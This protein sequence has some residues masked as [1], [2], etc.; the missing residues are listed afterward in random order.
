MLFWCICF[1][2]VREGEVAKRS[3]GYHYVPSCFGGSVFSNFKLSVWRNRLMLSSSLTCILYWMHS[4]WLIL[5]E[6]F[7]AYVKWVYKSYNSGV[8]LTGKICIQYFY[9]LTNGLTVLLS[10]PIIIVVTNFDACVSVFN[11]HCSNPPSWDLA[12]TAEVKAKLVMSCICS[13]G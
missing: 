3:G 11:S 5:K 10:T 2:L 12:S 7:L 1:L 8:W 13:W 6:S 9:A 4:R